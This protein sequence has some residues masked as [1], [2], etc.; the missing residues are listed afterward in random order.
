V[1]KLLTIAAWV[2]FAVD[3]FVIVA[4]VISRDM[5][6]DAAGRGMALS[7]GLIGLAFLLI[8]GAA[9]YFFGRAHS[10]P[11][12]AGSIALLALPLFLFFGSDVEAKFH[13]AGAWLSDRKVGR[14]PEPA[15]RELARAIE[16][17]DFQA[18]RKILATRPNLNGRDAAGHD[19]L[20]YAVKQ[21]RLLGPNRDS[22]RWV[23][24]VRLLLDA[25]MDPNQAREPDGTPVFVF[26]SKVL[27]DPAAAR[28]FRLFLEHGADP[29]G[30][31]TE[32]QPPIFNAWENLDSL[33]A[34]LDHGAQ[35][36]IRNRNG[37]TPLLFCAWG[38]R[39]NA[40]LLLL[41][42]GAALGVKNK[43]GTTLDAALDY[44]RAMAEQA[45]QPLPGGYSQ[46]KA[47][48]ERRRS[49][50]SR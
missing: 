10:W 38:G 15:Q 26:L 29:N 49:A 35:I 48:I 2:L 7:F 17:G 36:D 4:A 12:V 28:D 14:Y 42:R 3:A 1:L 16:A 13:D 45:Q 32:E 18:I 40:A 50:V 20:S 23:E 9:L 46:V 5:G 43:Q 19:L 33:R 30:P 22:E 31:A 27:D 11:G 6:D 39:W 37:D 44:Q 25:G 24:A 47:A 41:E 34:L 8:G 21:T